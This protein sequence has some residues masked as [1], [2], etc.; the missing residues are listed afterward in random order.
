[1]GGPMQYLGTL[2]SP[3]FAKW[4]AIGCLILM[5]AWSSAQANQLAAILNS[6]LIEGYQIPT[7]I[8]GVFIAI[9]VT[10][11]L[12]G[13]IKRISSL[14]SKLVPIM[15]TLYLGSCLWIIL[16]HSDKLGDILSLIFRSAF[17]PYALASG[18]IIGGIVSSLR[19]GIFKGTQTCEAGVGTQTIPHSMAE[20]NDP[21]AQGTLAM[22]STY[23][24]G[25]IAFLSGIVA[26]ITETWLDPQYPLGISMVLC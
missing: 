19:W 21:V 25:I 16:S 3:G 12:I 9:L 17:S 22:L 1:M 6:P 11:I 26:L 23:T 20:T 10:L 5:A 4:Y 18:T 14:S 2:L 24:A 15:F 13:G 8:S 7:P